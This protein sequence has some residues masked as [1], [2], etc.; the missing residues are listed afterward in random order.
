MILTEME[1]RALGSRGTAVGVCE[2]SAVLEETAAE[3]ILL[4][5]HCFIWAAAGFVNG[6]LCPSQH[7][8]AAL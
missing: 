5:P 6:P 4:L 3:G 2:L 8:G 1:T 7:S